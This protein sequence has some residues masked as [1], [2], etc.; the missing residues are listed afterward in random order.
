[1]CWSQP[2]DPNPSATVDPGHNFPGF[3]TLS[4]RGLFTGCGAKL[5]PKLWEPG[6]PNPPEV[7]PFD[8]PKPVLA[9]DP[10]LPV[11]PNPLDSKL[12]PLNPKCPL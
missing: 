6:A 12:V 11:D 8:P 9:A 4:C 3:S 10:K 2:K 7:D 1:M 5:E